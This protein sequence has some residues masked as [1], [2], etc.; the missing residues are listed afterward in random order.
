MGKEQLVHRHNGYCFASRTGF[1]LY[2]DLWTAWKNWYGISTKLNF[3]LM[4][5]FMIFH[6]LSGPFTW[7]EVLG[8]FRLIKL[9]PNGTLL[10]QQP[11]GTGERRLECTLVDK[12][13]E[14]ND[15]NQF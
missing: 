5:L 3:H 6:L 12:L 14:V 9:L 13:Y 7:S 15:N 8:H 2:N 10:K 1:I 4:S 11:Q